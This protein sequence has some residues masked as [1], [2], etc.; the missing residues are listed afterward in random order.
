MNG[1]A[2]FNL[3]DP[4]VSGKNIAKAIA[5][6]ESEYHRNV[7]DMYFFILFFQFFKISLFLGM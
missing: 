7:E 1:N 4:E 6:L 5:E 2:N 3:Q